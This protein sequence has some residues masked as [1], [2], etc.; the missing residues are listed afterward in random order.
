MNSSVGKQNSSRIKAC[1]VVAGSLGF[2]VFGFFLGGA[3]PLK[4]SG[5]VFGAAVGGIGL[6]VDA[7][8]ARCS[9]AVCLLVLQVCLS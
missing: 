3:P 2:A 8:L 5:V 4:F 9:A 7:Q 1:R 6:I